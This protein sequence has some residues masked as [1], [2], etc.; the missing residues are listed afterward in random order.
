MIKLEKKDKLNS[1]LQ[2]RS[3]KMCKAWISSGRIIKYQTLGKFMKDPMV[4]HFK[5]GSFFAIFCYANIVEMNWESSG[6]DSRIDNI[7]P[8]CVFEWWRSKFWN[9]GLMVFEWL[10]SFEWNTC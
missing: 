6:F 7:T 3:R 2:A 10:H 9:Y 1:I 5:D 4:E 8:D